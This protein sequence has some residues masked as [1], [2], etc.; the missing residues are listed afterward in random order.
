MYISHINPTVEFDIAI[1]NLILP[2]AN[3]IYISLYIVGYLCKYFKNRIVVLF[4]NGVW[5]RTLIWLCNHIDC[6]YDNNMVLCNIII[7]RQVVCRG[8]NAVRHSAVCSIFLCC[9]GCINIFFCINM[10][11]P[12]RLDVFFFSLPIVDD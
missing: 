2:T 4:H 5:K 8:P 9:D 6:I 7:N 10:S 1:V 11:D 3:Y 12:Q